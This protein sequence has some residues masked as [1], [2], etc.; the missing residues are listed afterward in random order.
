MDNL[1]LNLI[2]FI[3]FLTFYFKA[4]GYELAHNTL[5]SSEQWDLIKRA[6][7]ALRLRGLY[8]L[9]LTMDQSTTNVKM[10][11]ETGATANSPVI[12]IDDSELVIMFDTPHL[13]KSARNM[14]LKHNASFCNSVASFKWINELFEIDRCT[15]PR[16]VPKL[17]EDFINLAPFAAMNV[18]KAA[19]TLSNSVSKG[20]QFYVETEELAPEALGTATYAD[21]FDKLFDCLNSK[22]SQNDKKVRP[23]CQNSKFQQAIRNP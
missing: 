6:V 1:I 3:H 13:L 11:K 21:F 5:G 14:L 16:L 18:S 9:V 15:I 17:K 8:P 7:K 10:A 12:Q 20:I 23:S 2:S 19:R 22:A 4:F